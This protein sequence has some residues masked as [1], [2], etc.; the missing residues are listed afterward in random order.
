[1][2][3]EVCKIDD[4]LPGLEKDCCGQWSIIL[5]VWFAKEPILG[6]RCTNRTAFWLLKYEK[7]GLFAP[8]STGLNVLT[9]GTN[10]F[11]LSEHFS[12]Q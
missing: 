12:W 9:G 2:I 10:D 4:G 8:V 1:M 3:F 6:R 5:R 11:I 7:N